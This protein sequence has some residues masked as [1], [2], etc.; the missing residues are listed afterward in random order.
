MCS[1]LDELELEVFRRAFLALVEVVE[2]AAFAGR[3]E[4]IHEQKGER[5]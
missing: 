4:L 5:K 3:L 1:D 2:A